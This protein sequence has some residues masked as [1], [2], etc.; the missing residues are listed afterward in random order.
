MRTAGSGLAVSTL[1]GNLGYVEGVVDVS[2]V[3]PSCFSNPLKECAIDFLTE[4]LTQKRRE[5]I[6]VTAVIGAYTLQLDTKGAEDPGEECAR[7]IFENQ[8]SSALFAGIS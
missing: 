3:V 6:P 4:V 1:K 5:I 2:I 8:V 7:R